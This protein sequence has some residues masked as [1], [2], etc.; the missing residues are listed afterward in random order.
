MTI[1]YGG[2]PRGAEVVQ[3]VEVLRGTS[4]AD[5]TPR[6][7][8]GRVV[9]GAPDGD[10]L[11]RR[12]RDN[13]ALWANRAGRIA[14]ADYMAARAED[15]VLTLFRID[16]SHHLHIYDGRGR[17]VEDVTGE[18]TDEA[19]ARQLARAEWWR[20]REDAAAEPWRWETR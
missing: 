6:L 16:G 2:P 19:T 3:R 11:S 20:L 14:L 18:P 5:W 12:R 13:H 1:S 8:G 9:L 4:A 17:L 10:G 15:R 7:P